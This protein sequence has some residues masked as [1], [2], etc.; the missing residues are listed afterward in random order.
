MQTEIK[1]RHKW[2]FILTEQDLRR[3]IQTC[4]EHGEKLCTGSVQQK[5]SA[6]LRDG[7]VTESANIDD[8]V[9]LENIGKRRI[10]KLHLVWSPAGM[11]DVRKS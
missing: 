2:G 4:R 5:F 11:F 6:K 10:E 9:G 7:A 1:R 3:I 8:I